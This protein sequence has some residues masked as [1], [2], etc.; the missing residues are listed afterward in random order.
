MGGEQRSEI[1]LVFTTAVAVLKI[2]STKHRSYH[3]H[4][5]FK[6]VS[7]CVVRDLFDTRSSTM[8]TM[9]QKWRRMGSGTRLDQVIALF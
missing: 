6:S 4:A 3:R 2:L 9:K 7:W 8:L 1:L 5:K